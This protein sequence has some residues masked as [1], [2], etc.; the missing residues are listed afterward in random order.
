MAD[1]GEVLDV[2]GQLG[3]SDE[4]NRTSVWSDMAQRLQEMIVN[5]LN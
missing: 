5:Q 4:E 1:T 2:A 3:E